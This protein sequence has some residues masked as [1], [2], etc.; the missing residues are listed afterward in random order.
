MANK[1]DFYEVLGVARDADERAIKKAYRKLA[2]QHH[3]DRNP[4]D[5]EAEEKFK[6]AA[7]AYAILSDRDKRGIYDRY[8]HAGLSQAGAGG[9]PDMNDIFSSF[10]DIFSEFFGF[11][12][13]RP[14]DPNAPRRGDDLQMQIDVPFE[15]V[16]HGGS[17]PLRVPRRETCGSCNG[18]GGRDGAKPVTCPSCKGVG[19]VRHSQGL[20]TIQTTC[21]RCRGRGEIIADPC[22]ACNGEGQVRRE[23]EVTVRIPAG[24]TTGNR[25]RIRNEGEDGR[26]GGPPGDLYLL[27]RVEEPDVFERD[28]ADLHLVVPIDF[29]VAA[30]G[31]EIEI[32]S[33]DGTETVTIAPGT[34][35]GDVHRLRGEGL[36]RVN[37]SDRGDLFAHVRIEVPKKLSKR[38]RELL[39]ALAAEGGVKTKTR[40]G[41]FDRIKSLFERPEVDDEAAEPDVDDGNGDASTS[42]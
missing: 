35:H 27:L 33:L 4:G 30:L 16:V 1:P 17:I 39:E 26:N 11:G 2:L 25:L 28:G 29:T 14:R 7:E 40:H 31:G 12:G 13:G 23:H 38:Q 18:T 24:V 34:Q 36:P 37:R 32:P 3:P 6:L 15:Y 9:G 5:A 20:F 8:G 10:G 41:F 22:P 19:Q 21:P 42:D